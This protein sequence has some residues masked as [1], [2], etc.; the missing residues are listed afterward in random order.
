MIKVDGQTI[1]NQVVILDGY[2]YKECTF[3]RCQLIFSGTGGYGLEGCNISPDSGF[4]FNGP[5]QNTLNFLSGV[6]R[7]NPNGKALVETIFQSIRAGLPPQPAV[8]PQPEKPTGP[9]N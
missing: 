2:Q 4:G 6:Y 5:A 9:V 3:S 7:S 1:Q 8:A